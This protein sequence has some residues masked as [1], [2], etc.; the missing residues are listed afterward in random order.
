[1]EEENVQEYETEEVMK[2]STE[3]AEEIYEEDV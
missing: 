2:K 3:E 1:M